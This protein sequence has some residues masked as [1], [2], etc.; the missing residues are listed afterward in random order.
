MMHSHRNE[1]IDFVL[2]GFMNMANGLRNIANNPALPEMVRSE[3]SALADTAQCVVGPV[4]TMMTND[5]LSGIGPRSSGIRDA[6]TWLKL[7]VDGIDFRRL[8]PKVSFDW[9]TSVENADDHELFMRSWS[10]FFYTQYPLELFS[11]EDCTIK[12]KY[13]VDGYSFEVTAFAQL[14]TMEPGDPLPT[15]VWIKEVQVSYE[16]QEKYWRGW[17]TIPRSSALFRDN[18]VSDV[19][20]THH[21]EEVMLSTALKGVV[22]FMTDYVITPLVH[23]LG[24]SFKEYSLAGG[25]GY[26]DDL[27]GMLDELAEEYPEH[28]K[29]HVRNIIT[30]ECSNM[31]CAKGMDIEVPDVGTVRIVTGESDLYDYDKWVTKTAEH[32]WYR[33]KPLLKIYSIMVA[34]VDISTR[35]IPTAWNH[36]ITEAIYGAFRK[37]CENYSHWPKSPEELAD[38]KVAKEQE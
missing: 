37:Y 22:P 29:N 12:V 2:S 36:R 5:I 26:K 8:A 27:K 15:L 6:A 3:F 32:S 18:P 31:G 7:P 25:L 34:G 30:R 14:S 11:D 28:H 9:W 19:S 20:I 1:P 33:D 4:Q 10:Q 13:V 23:R 17:I 21:V 35:R 24:Y 16:P 38:E